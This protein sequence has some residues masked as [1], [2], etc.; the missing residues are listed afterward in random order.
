LRPHNGAWSRHARPTG[1]VWRAHKRPT[2]VERATLERV[3]TRRLERGALRRRPSHRQGPGA[4]IRIQRRGRCHCALQRHL[5]TVS[6]RAH[7]N[8]C[9]LTF[10]TI[11]PAA[12]A[13]PRNVEAT[14]SGT[15]GSSRASSWQVDITPHTAGTAGVME[16]EPRARTALRMQIGWWF[17]GGSA[18]S[19]RN[20]SRGVVVAGVLRVSGESGTKSRFYSLTILLRSSN[21]TPARILFPRDA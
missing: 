8:G 7:T 19:S 14:E 11:P 1:E 5:P 10:D 18:V 20:T 9:P 2:E 15:R 12:A 21:R 3:A 16:G 6:C 4:R 13:N 17:E